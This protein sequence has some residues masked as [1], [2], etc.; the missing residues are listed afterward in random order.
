[1]SKSKSKF[2]LAVCGR[3]RVELSTRFVLWLKERACQ[4]LAVSCLP[5]K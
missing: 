3:F 4:L 2:P 5:V 1:M